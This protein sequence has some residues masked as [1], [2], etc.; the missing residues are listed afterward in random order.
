[1]HLN[2]T[3]WP[4]T[5]PSSLDVEVGARWEKDVHGL[6]GTQPA[7]QRG[8]TVSLLGT[9]QPQVILAHGHLSLCWGLPSHKPSWCNMGL[10]PRWRHPIMPSW[11]KTQQG[12][13]K[14]RINKRFGHIVKLPS[15]DRTRAL[16]LYQRECRPNLTVPT[17]HGCTQS[18]S[19][20]VKE[21]TTF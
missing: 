4:D 11:R 1:M 21:T 17:R 16:A 18:T 19:T 5:S 8:V 2:K 6:N 14:Q 3:H 7:S 15:P 10:L 12:A 9:P 20:T 13:T